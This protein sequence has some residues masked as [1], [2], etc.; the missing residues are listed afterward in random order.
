MGKKVLDTTFTGPKGN[1]QVKTKNFELN[2]KCPKMD[3]KKVVRPFRLT[4]VQADD[5]IVA[6]PFVF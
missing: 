4:Q 1:K 5:N 6:Q 3:D 2:R